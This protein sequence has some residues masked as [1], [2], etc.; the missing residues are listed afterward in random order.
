MS[1]SNECPYNIVGMIMVSVTK[2]I[3]FTNL[4]TNDL[5]TNTKTCIK[6]K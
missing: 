5:V 6:M 4:C 3:S 2:R 1:I